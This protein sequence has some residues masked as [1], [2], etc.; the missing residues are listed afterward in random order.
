MV[1]SEVQT[2]D[3]NL[4]LRETVALQCTNAI[5]FIFPICESESLCLNEHE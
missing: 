3:I 5:V 1:F 2:Q 4:Q